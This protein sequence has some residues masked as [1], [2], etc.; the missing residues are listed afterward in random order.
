[1][2]V[3]EVFVAG[4]PVGQGA[5]SFLGKG[6]PAVHTNAKRLKPWRQAIVA[7]T[8]RAMDEIGMREP[9]DGPAVLTAVFSMP[10]G[11][12]VKRLLPSVPPDWDHLGRA[13]SD[14]LTMAG[15]VADDAR[16]V[17]A[18]TTKLYATESFPP[19]VAFRLQPLP[20]TGYGAVDWPTP[21]S[22]RAK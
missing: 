16:I 9:L 20:A 5:V 3:L 2:T 13:L 14:A 6:R 21:E 8:C 18:H 7:E 1:M 19:G 10:R 22:R 11:K 17:E 12:T 15:A 4:E